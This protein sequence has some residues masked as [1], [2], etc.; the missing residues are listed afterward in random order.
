VV[1]AGNVIMA[2]DPSGNLLIRDCVKES[3]PNPS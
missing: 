2:I 3:E 1:S